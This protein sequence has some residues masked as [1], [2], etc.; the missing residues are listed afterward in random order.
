MNESQ[1][2]DARDEA[3]T[4]VSKNEFTM[5]QL[6][7][8]AEQTL[9]G[10]VIELLQTNRLFG[11]VLIQIPRYYNTNLNGAMGFKWSETQLT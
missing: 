1:F 5:D 11:E 10:A 4:A 7:K 8:Y 6:Q 3:L 9:S 2:K